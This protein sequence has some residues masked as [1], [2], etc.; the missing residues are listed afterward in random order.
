MYQL[1]EA[2]N[3]RFYTELPVNYGL[4]WAV[5]PG[6]EQRFTKLAQNSDSIAP[7]L[8]GQKEKVIE[9]ETDVVE[10]NGIEELNVYCSE[11]Y[12]SNS[13]S[14]FLNDRPKGQF[15]KNFENL[16]NA[17]GKITL[18]RGVVNSDCKLLVVNF[19]PMR[20]AGLN[21]PTKFKL[22]YD[23]QDLLFGKVQ[24]IEYISIPLY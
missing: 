20:K 2:G 19:W 9:I 8:I 16:K 12:L 11:E 21:P 13:M 1:S 24:A 18:T 15:I 6:A 4:T 14:S 10:S 5:A 7:L 22:R 17:E 23:N 3:W